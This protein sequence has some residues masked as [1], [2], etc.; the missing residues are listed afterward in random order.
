MTVRIVTQRLELVSATVELLRGALA[1]RKE[2]GERLDA[3]VPPTWPPD[4]LDPAALEYTIARLAEGSDQEGWWMYFVV[5][6]DDKP[7]VLIGSAGYKGPPGP[8]RA[9][10]IGYGI[11]SDYRRRGF[12]SEA[13][14]A[15]VAQGFVVP[16]VDRV[17]AETLPS[18]AGSIGVL[19]KARFSLKRRFGTG[20]DQ[21][22][23]DAP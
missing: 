5:L 19:E 2:L 16:G 22:R 21:I 17:I 20:R 18:L 12:A 1:G 15:L 9:V 10:E 3:T 7:S 13:A 6:R 11:V 4:F 23:I 8:D 14:A